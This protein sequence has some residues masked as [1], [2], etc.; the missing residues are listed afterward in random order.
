M[1]KLLNKDRGGSCHDMRDRNE[2]RCTGVAKRQL[3]KT[4]V[5][6]IHVAAS[7][8]ETK[9]QEV[10]RSSSGILLIY[11][12]TRR[13]LLKYMYMWQCYWAV[14]INNVSS[15]FFTEVFGSGM[16][17]LLNVYCYSLMWHYIDWWY[18]TEYYKCSCNNKQ[19]QF[20]SSLCFDSV[21]IYKCIQGRVQEI[22]KGELYQ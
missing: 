21:M 2:Q 19:T 8:A 4:N 15:T 11:S 18:T 20:T 14:K 16:C 13:C 1:S 3:A 7:H 9:G 22:S 6:H 5:W 12:N 10:C 17:Q